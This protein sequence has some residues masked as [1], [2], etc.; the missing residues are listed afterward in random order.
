M[1]QAWWRWK[2]FFDEKPQQLPDQS[3]SEEY[4]KGLMYTRYLPVS[5][6][7]VK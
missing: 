3:S 4:V 1:D 5:I 2:Q 6:D 7:K